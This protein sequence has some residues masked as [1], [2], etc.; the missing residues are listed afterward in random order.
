MV[1]SLASSGTY[2]MPHLATSLVSCIQTFFII[3]ERVV[4]H[5]QIPVQQIAPVRGHPRSK[6]TCDTGH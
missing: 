3:A 2:L 4:S 6:D 1:T 5:G